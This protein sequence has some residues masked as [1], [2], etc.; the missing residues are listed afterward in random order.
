MQKIVTAR[1][2]FKEKGPAGILYVTLLKL[3]LPANYPWLT[4][5]LLRRQDPYLV[6]VREMGT[7]PHCHSPLEQTADGL[8]CR[9][10]RDVYV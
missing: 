10:C 9:Q 6:D 2:V 5:R 7:C 4:D 3:G 8:L 1:R